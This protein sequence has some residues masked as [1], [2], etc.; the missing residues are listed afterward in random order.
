M[1]RDLYDNY[2]VAGRVLDR[3]KE[4]LGKE[5]LDLCF[6]GPESELKR[7]V[8]AQPAILT[9]SVA[10][11]ALLEENGIRPDIVAGHSLGEY[12]ALVAAGSL[13]FDDAVRLVRKRG[14]YMQEAVPLGVGGMVAVLGLD[15][16][17]VQE[18]CEHVS[19]IHPGTVEAANLNSPSQVVIAGDKESLQIAMRMLNEKGAKKCVPLSVSAPFHSSMMRPA[20]ERLAADLNMISIKDPVL[21][22]MCNVTAGYHGGGGEIREMLVHQV[23]SPVRWQEC[24]E[25]M[26]HDGVEMFVE[27]G[28]GRVLS[29]LIKKI[30]KNIGIINVDNGV[31]LQKALACLRE[32]G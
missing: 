29:G 30:N 6:T 28:P 14:R 31:S 27:V 20:G 18:V 21:P 23:Y 15:P 25:M 1:G 17:L 10:C 3:S 8:N 24:V 2:P 4:L 32:V 19:S 22:V 5:I 11:L 26:V 12:S 13:T 16:A 7:T 9:V